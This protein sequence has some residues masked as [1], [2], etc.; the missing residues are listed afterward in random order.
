MS[1]KKQTTIKVNLPSGRTAIIDTPIKA[2]VAKCEDLTLLGSMG[3]W[4]IYELPNLEV[5]IV[6]A[7]VKS[8]VKGI[9]P[10]TLATMFETTN[11]TPE[12]AVAQ[13]LARFE[14]TLP[15]TG[16]FQL[17]LA[18]HKWVETLPEEKTE[19]QETEVTGDD[20]M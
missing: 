13:G 6:E 11:L 1:S 17:K 4:F 9:G 10:S 7:E 15:E 20:L 5:V 19:T 8:N 3:R 2:K 18:K 14:H 12:L 16:F